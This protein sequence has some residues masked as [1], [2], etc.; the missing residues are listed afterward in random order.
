MSQHPPLLPAIA[1]GVALGIA[2]TLSPLTVIVL[3]PCAAGL[4]RFAR[5]LPAD[6]RWWLVR[7][8]G[9]ALVMRIA[10]IGALFLA[11]AHDSQASAALF[12]DE[13]YA[14]ARSWRIRNVVLGIPQLKYDY[15]IAFEG[16]GRTSYLWV[17]T[18]LQVLAGPAP[19][20]LRVLNAGLFLGAVL[21]LFR[22]IRRAF[23][24]FTAFSGSLIL[25][26]LPT[27]FI[28]SISLLKE[29]FYFVLTVTVLTAV[30][31]LT[32]TATSWRARAVCGAGIAVALLALR[33]LREGA[34]VLAV[35][36]IAAGLAGAWVLGRRVR[37]AIVATVIAAVVAAA[38]LAPPLRSRA[39]DLVAQAATANAG[40]VFTVGHGYKL[41]D[42]EFYVVPGAK[43]RFDL[44]LPEALR[45]VL[46]AA[47]SY[48]VVPLPWQMATR[49]ELV[50]L[51]E[52]IF[53]YGVLILAPAGA[54]AAARRNRIAASLL[55]AYLVPTAV[56]VA[57]TTGNVGTLIRHRTL[58]VP[59]VVW[60]GALGLASLAQRVMR[61]QEVAP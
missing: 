39:L 38:V 43:P 21:L 49:G 16:Y 57:M 48:L 25:L 45:Y 28:W 9:L 3:V 35:T 17:M 59:F 30:V 2:F 15:M 27:L 7:I 29:S 20:G 51:P 41:L 61:Q 40:H 50:Y 23:G 54:I 44:G 52:Q 13:A 42:D 47:A 6:E 19:Y 26:F 10:A 58:I 33:D 22:M 32:T 56:V 34:V 36:G 46:R 5:T 4:W 12:G 18:Y 14:L 31:E 37:I 1:A 53:W 60:L 8:F 11:S 24:A 55:V